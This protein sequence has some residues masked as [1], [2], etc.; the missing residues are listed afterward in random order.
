MTTLDEC[1]ELALAI[2]D[3]GTREHFA[4]DPL[5][6]LRDELHIVAKPAEHLVALRSGGGACDGTSFLDDGVIL[7]APSLNSRR[8]NFTLGH[9]LG[10][11]LVE[12]LDDVL[13][14]IADQRDPSAVVESVCDRIAQR[15]LLPE[16]LIDSVVGN[17]PVRARHVV[18]LFDASLA[19]HPVCAI[20]LA[21]RLP[22]LGSVAIIDPGG[23]RVQY[24]SVATDS[25]GGWP[26]IFPWPGHDVPAGH[27]TLTIVPGTEVTRRSFWRTPWGDQ[28][29]YYIDAVRFGHRVAAV[30]AEHDLWGAERLHLDTGSSVDDRPETEHFCCGERQTARGYPCGDCGGPYC[31]ICKLCPCQ[32]SA[33]AEQLCA[34]TCFMKFRPNLLENGLCEECR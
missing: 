32:R 11:W 3:P 1:A 6:A 27:P 24:A 8:Q 2:V 30:L 7:Y 4:L 22:C 17:G 16:E 13:D 19:S 15:L 29:D 21:R 14:W 34:G 25:A 10:H 5:T 12:Q 31:R 26:S 9:E 18:E 20:G 23:R 33:A 28:Q